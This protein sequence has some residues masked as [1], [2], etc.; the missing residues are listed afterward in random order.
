LGWS[1][2]Q[3][4]CRFGE[5]IMI[6]KLTEQVIRP[7]FYVRALSVGWGSKIHFEVY[8]KGAVF[9]KPL[10]GTISGNGRFYHVRTRHWIE[11]ANDSYYVCKKC[12]KKLEKYPNL[13]VEH[14]NTPF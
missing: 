2:R 11:R 9:D 4:K 14:E 3:Y 7:V 13:E 6:I 12:A 1:Y 8:K 10:C 5:D